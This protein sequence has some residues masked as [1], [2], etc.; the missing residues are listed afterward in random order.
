LPYKYKINQRNYTTMKN[1]KPSELLAIRY[2]PAPFHS[3][4]SLFNIE[5]FSLTNI[6]QYFYNASNTEVLF[7]DSIVIKGIYLKLFEDKNKEKAMR[8]DHPNFPNNLLTNKNS[9]QYEAAFG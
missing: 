3:N 5:E 4:R 1:F 9:R 7:G 2:Q 6:L 8:F